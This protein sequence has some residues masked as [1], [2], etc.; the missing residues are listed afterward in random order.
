MI[1]ESHLQEKRQSSPPQSYL[2]QTIRRIA[3]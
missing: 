1:R 3:D 2:Q